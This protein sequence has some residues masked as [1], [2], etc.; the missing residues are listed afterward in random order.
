MHE[1]RIVY[2]ELEQPIFWKLLEG[3]QRNTSGHFG[4]RK[5]EILLKKDP[6]TCVSYLGKYLK[7]DDFC[8]LGMFTFDV[9]QY[10]T[11]AISFICYICNVT[12]NVNKK[13]LQIALLE[14]P[15]YRINKPVSFLENLTQ[16]IFNDSLK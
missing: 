4:I 2:R 16:I 13:I 14:P 9:F 1:S 15:S 12:L 5:P 11:I 8:Q 6:T 7:M 10:L 3:L